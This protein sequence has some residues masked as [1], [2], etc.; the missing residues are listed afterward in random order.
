[1]CMKIKVM[2]DDK[3]REKRHKKAKNK[4]V[5]AK[6]VHFK[7]KGDRGGRLTKLSFKD[8]KTKLP[9][10]PFFTWCKGLVPTGKK[11][12]KYN[13]WRPKTKHASTYMEHMP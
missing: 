10:N 4:E 3:L 13:I 1:M 7:A 12:G 2:D 5:E 11:D 9:L 8:L 6:D